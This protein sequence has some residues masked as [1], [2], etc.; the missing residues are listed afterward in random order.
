MTGGTKSMQAALELT[1]AN[2]EV[3]QHNTDV[4]NEKVKAGGQTIEGWAD[5]QK[6]FN[7]RMSEAKGSVEALGIQIGQ[8]LLPKVQLVLDAITML[9]GWLAKHKE[10]ASALAIVIGTLATTFVA[11]K[12]GM[13]AY[14]GVL[15]AIMVATKL[16]TAAQWLLNLA[17]DANP[18]GLIVIAIAAIAAGVYLLWTNSKGFR[19]FFIGLWGDIW[20]FLKAV[21]AWFAGPFANFFV[22]VGK[23]IAAPFIWLWHNI[24]YPIWQAFILTMRVVMQIVTSFR[25]L[26]LDIAYDVFKPIWDN[27]LKPF[28]NG[29]KIEFEFIWHNVLLPAGQAFML[30]LH[31][32]GDVFSWLWHN[33][34]EPWAHGVGVVIHG[35]IEFIHSRFDALMD[36]VHAVGKVFSDVFSAI[37]GFISSAF[38]DAVSTVKSAINGVI[39]IVNSAIG[40]INSNVIDQANQLP[41]VNFPHLPTI[42][43][44]ASGGYIGQGGLAVVGERGPEVVSLPTGATVYPNGSSPT[45]GAA[46]MDFSGDLDGAFATLFK[47]LVRRGKITFYDSSGKK[48]TV[49]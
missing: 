3:F 25:N 44:L 22:K 18:V 36:K 7:Q 24:L 45:G 13:L 16:W 30:V 21:G 10:V 32:I 19:D 11:W 48:L 31:A 1:G 38:H 14:E 33:A 49:A 23:D 27:V 28:F 37:G 42:P 8:A 35:V 39:R 12:V 41:G 15:K 43:Y 2:M 47:S 6:N 34:I 46:N 40:F 9:V 4:I 17:M 26:F 20:G 29:V 5:V